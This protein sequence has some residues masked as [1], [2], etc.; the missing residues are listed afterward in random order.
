MPR[1]DQ[2]GDRSADCDVFSSPGSWTCNWRALCWNCT[3][4][5]LER[6]FFCFFFLLFRRWP[7][8]LSFRNR[9]PL[10]FCRVSDP[11]SPGTRRLFNQDCSQSAARHAAA[12]DQRIQGQAMC[13]EPL[14]QHQP[15]QPLAKSFPGDVTWLLFGWMFDLQSFSFDKVCVCVCVPPSSQLPSGALFFPWLLA[16]VS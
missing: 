10:T 12:G 3:I 9:T 7:G 1:S 13:A 11:F 2:T 15:R 8:W 6:V 16:S 4:A 14:A 5:L